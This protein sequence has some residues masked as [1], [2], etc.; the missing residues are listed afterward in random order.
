MKRNCTRNR[1]FKGDNCWLAPYANI[2]SP[3]NANKTPSPC[4][5][6]F[7]WVK[8]G[9]GNSNCRTNQDSLLGS[10][11][12]EKSWVIFSAISYSWAFLMKFLLKMLAGISPE[13]LRLPSCISDRHWCHIETLRETIRNAAMRLLRGKK[14]DWSL[15]I[16]TAPANAFSWSK[17]KTWLYGNSL[18]RVTIIV[19]IW[20]K[21]ISLAAESAIT[22]SFHCLWNNL[23]EYFIIIALGSF[24]GAFNVFFMPEE[25][26]NIL[27]VLFPLCFLAKR[28]IET[29]PSGRDKGTPIVIVKQGYEP[30]TFTGWF[31]AWDSNK[32]KNWRTRESFSFKPKSDERTS[33]F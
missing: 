29:D 11:S 16:C 13:Q 6:T 15:R 25:W 19:L 4:I 9:G 32:W 10:L 20:W 8:L 1:N 31:L 2:C 24:T 23:I 12:I 7:H 30:P 28:Y 18:T 17:A 22:W 33:I 27:H 21:I 14:W 3:R 5:A 26:T